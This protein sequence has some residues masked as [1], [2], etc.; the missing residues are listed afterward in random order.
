MTEDNIG[1]R[2]W[3][4][5]PGAGAQNWD[6]F[7]D[8]K[9]ISIDWAPDTDFRKTKFGDLTTNPDFEKIKMVLGEYEEFK[10]KNPAQS[11]VIIRRFL[12]IKPGDKVVVY[13]KKFH[14][15]AI[16]EVIGE[17]EWKKDVGYPHT[18]KVK[19][20]KIFGP[21]FD[22]HGNVL[23]E[24]AVP[25]DIR[26]IL[27]TLKINI[28]GK[29]TVIEMNKKD[30]DTIFNY[31]KQVGGKIEKSEEKTTS[32]EILKNLFNQ[33]R[34]ELGSNK[35][36]NLDDVLSRMKQIAEA[37]GQQ[38]SNNWENVAIEQIRNEWARDKPGT[39]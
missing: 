24:D 16:S 22:D 39:K 21:Q 14:I 27:D 12:E 34:L 28:G 2:Y 36:L 26:P 6:V 25:L 18:K 13:D 9:I 19:W 4:V 30:W 17:Y 8:E 23:N 31:A 20:V 32:D 7:R 33:A 35:I 15:N 1:V 3:K 5:S 37:K 10:E 11:A 38:L 29:K